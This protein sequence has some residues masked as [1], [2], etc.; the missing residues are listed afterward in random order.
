MTCCIKIRYDTGRVLSVPL[1]CVLDG[2]GER[3]WNGKPA[4]LLQLFL[5]LLLKVR[6]QA[7]QTSRVLIGG[8]G[9][10]RTDKVMK[11]YV[12][13]LGYRRRGKEEKLWI[14]SKVTIFFFC[15]CSFL[16]PLSFVVF[17][18]LPFCVLFLSLSCVFPSPLAF[19]LSHHKENHKDPIRCHRCTSLL[20]DFLCKQNIFDK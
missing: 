19:S 5:P 3:A 2:G 7:A 15:H 17:C 11:G 1:C 14:L 20:D 10:P 9:G 12:R 6:V 13:H 18:L 4:R 8:I 16:I